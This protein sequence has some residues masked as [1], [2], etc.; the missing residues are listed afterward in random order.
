MCDAV[1]DV[2]CVCV[3]CTVCCVCPGGGGSLGRYEL[4]STDHVPAAP[5]EAPLHCA[6]FL[7]LCFQREPAARATAAQL[8][9]HP[10]LVH[11]TDDV[12][13]VGRLDDEDM[14]GRMPA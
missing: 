12:G 4:C 13:A 14:T 6:A 9:E 2:V 7:A 11:H 3:W 8:L 1:C 5:P 10:F